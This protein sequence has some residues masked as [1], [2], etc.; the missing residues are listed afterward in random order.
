M[1]INNNL[2]IKTNTCIAANND[3][4]AES[5]S[6]SFNGLNITQL[7][8]DIHAIFFKYL[9]SDSMKA[10]RETNKQF[11]EV[12][13]T[14]RI[15]KK[16]KAERE[17]HQEKVLAEFLSLSLVD[18]EGKPIHKMAYVKLSTPQERNNLAKLIM[19]IFDSKT[20]T[21]YMIENNNVFCQAF[22]HHTIGNH[23]PLR[24]NW[25]KHLPQQSFQNSEITWIQSITFEIIWAYHHS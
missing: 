21:K 14:D 5:S 7:P 24:E 22:K 19:K 10:L 11:S 6:A 9:D 12:I 25:H 3:H 20:L 23:L 13:S 15:I 4:L 17:L 16:I 1:N 8:Y 18:N 2:N